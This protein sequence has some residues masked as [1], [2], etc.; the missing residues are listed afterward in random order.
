MTAYTAC[1][2]EVEAVGAT[3]IEELLHVDG[4]IVFG[5]TW[6]DLPGFMKE[7]FKLMNIK[8]ESTV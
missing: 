2:P 7:Y 6:P 3:Y 5:H 8:K 4:N 1:R